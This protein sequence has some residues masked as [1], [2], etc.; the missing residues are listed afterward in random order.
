[1]GSSL[2]TPI[3]SFSTAQGSRFHIFAVGVKTS[4]WVQTKRDDCINTTLLVLPDPSKIG[5]STLSFC[6][7]FFQ[8]FLSYF[9]SFH[10][11]SKIGEI[12]CMIGIIKWFLEHLNWI[13]VVN[14]MN[15]TT[16]L[17]KLIKPDSIRLEPNRYRHH[18]NDF[19]GIS[20]KNLQSALAAHLIDLQILYNFLVDVI[21]SPQPIL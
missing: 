15:S 18:I 8:V 11:E 2:T 16:C 13:I 9:T 19:P 6:A 10:R 1:M 3:S 12:Q 21:R 7:V 17:T 20:Q 5:P 4:A 14:M